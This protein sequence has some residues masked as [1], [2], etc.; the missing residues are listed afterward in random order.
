MSHPQIPKASADRPSESEEQEGTRPGGEGGARQVPRFGEFQG[1]QAWYERK[2]Q[3]LTVGI[4]SSAVSDLGTLQ[5]IQL[6]EEGDQ[7]K[8]GSFL[9][10]FDGSS[11][12]FELLSPVRGEV[13]QVNE[14]ALSEP[15]R[16]ADDP[17][18]EG[19]LLKIALSNPQDLL[20][21]D[22]PEDS[23]ESEEESEDDEDSEGD[24]DD[25]DEEGDSDES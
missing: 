25:R 2:A 22:D 8:K 10:E 21:I 14:L 9:G 5:G 15:E 18:E 19:W 6:A 4:T 17:V 12:S 7:L 16:I 20:N 23:D 11:D 3:I 13:I 1:G 24:G